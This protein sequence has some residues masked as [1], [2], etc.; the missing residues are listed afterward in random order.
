M[1]SSSL[2]AMRLFGVFVLML[3]G[4][5]FPALTAAVD[6]TD[7]TEEEDNLKQAAIELGR[8]YDAFY[9]EKNAAAMASLYTADGELVSPAGPVVQGREAL[10]DYYTKRFASGAHGHKIHVLEAHAQGKGGYSLADF[11]VRIAHDHLEETEEGHIVAIYQ[12]EPDGWHFRLV[13]PSV[14]RPPT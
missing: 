5:I 12:R 13:E 9:G 4:S 11:S 14:P 3:G 10:E 8:Q 6:E 2:S 1:L 7:I